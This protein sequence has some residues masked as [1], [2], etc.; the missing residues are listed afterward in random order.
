MFWFFSCWSQNGLYKQ[1]TYKTPPQLLF[2]TYYWLRPSVNT[3]I[4]TPILKK[5]YVFSKC[6]NRS[7]G[8]AFHFRQIQDKI[9]QN[10]N[11][12]LIKHTSKLLMRMSTCLVEILFQKYHNLQSIE[13][14]VQ[15]SMEHHHHLLDVVHLLPDEGVHL[16]NGDEILNRKIHNLQWIILLF[17]K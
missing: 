3:L 11:V 14:Q 8:S 6:P 16:L 4:L 7:E 12:L 1:K 15:R 10:L 5:V 17:I 2:L 13:H 9:W